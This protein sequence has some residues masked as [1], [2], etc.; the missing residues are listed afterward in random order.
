M[1]LLLLI[2]DDKSHY[3]YIK[4]FNRFMFH[5]M[6]NKN[7]KHCCKSCLQLFSSKY[8]L[9]KHKEICL[10]INGVQCI[11][12]EKGI[13]KFKNYSKKYQFHLKFMLILSLYYRA[14]KFLKAL[15]QRCIKIMFLVDLL[16]KLF[17][18]MI[19]LLS[20]QLFLEVKM[21]LMNL[22]KQFLRSMNTV[23]K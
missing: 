4:D 22:L 9:T 11:R 17:V 21:L 12:L 18:L 7:N 16:T 1:D 6:K 8:V 15:T 14:L 20:Q 13:I 23:K 2:D 10:N 19:N 3:V 5:K